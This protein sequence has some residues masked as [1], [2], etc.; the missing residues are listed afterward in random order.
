MR[1]GPP[2]WALLQRWESSARAALADQLEGRWRAENA[3]HPDADHVHRPGRRPVELAGAAAAATPA[4]NDGGA[5]AVEGE[6]NSVPPLLVDAQ[7]QTSPAPTPQP[8]PSTE[9]EERLAASE[10]H[11][12][13]MRQA[14]RHW[15]NQSD[16]AQEQL[17][18]LRQQVQQL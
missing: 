8:T 14:A 15:K 9:S 12:N 6:D 7:S 18:E 2:A 16:K 11:L 5:M 13:K 10:A 17:Q 3:H 4:E 1:G